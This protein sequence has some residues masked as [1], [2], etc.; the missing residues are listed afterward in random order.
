MAA[1]LQFRLT[2]GASNTDP[3]A[4]LGGVMSGTEV[5]SSPMN[6]LFD[7]VSPAE[8]SSGDTE[9]RAIDIYNS[10]DTTATEV[11]IYMSTETS[12]PDTQ[13][14]LGYDSAGAHASDWNG[15]SITDEGDTPADSGGGNISF[16]HHTSGNKLT[17]PDIPAGQA[18]R[19]WLK[20]IVSAGAGN[21][22]SDQGTL[23][24]EYA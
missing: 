7:N 8:A 11:A 22:S 12:S 20:R 17:L 13:I 16:A 1:T 15:P 10:G 3:N 23:T 6:N 4:S 5:S 24:V 2:G 19:V 14:D 21:T 9:Y 18:V